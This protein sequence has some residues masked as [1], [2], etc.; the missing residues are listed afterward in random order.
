M[1]FITFIQL[2]KY[3]IALIIIASVI[4]FIFLFLFFLTLFC[5]L[6]F[7]FKIK[8]R[9]AS[10]NLLIN[11]R[12]DLMKKIIKYAETKGIVINKIHKKNISALDRIN[13]FQMLDKSTRDTKLLDYLYTSSTII[14][15]L[16]QVSEIA[17]DETFQELN[18]IYQDTENQYRINVTFYNS[19]ITGYNY[20]ADMYFLK[21]IMHFLGFKNKSTIV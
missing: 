15:Q 1:T 4:V 11:E 7:R 3:Q 14:S 9:S 20:W 13:D 10:I 5:L 18:L 8:N 19:D 21:H 17:S 12:R 16:S 6:R 2:E